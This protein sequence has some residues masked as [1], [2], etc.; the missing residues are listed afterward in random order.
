[1]SVL[2]GNCD[3]YYQAIAILHILTFRAIGDAYD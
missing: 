3:D 1:M 2:F